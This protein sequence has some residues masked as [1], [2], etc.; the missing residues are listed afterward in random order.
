MQEVQ[1]I[2]VSV[3]EDEG[4]LNVSEQA[5]LTVDRFPKQVY[6]QPFAAALDDFAELGGQS[7]AR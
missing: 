1:G 7:D 4:D 3:G 2:V 5:V 6:S